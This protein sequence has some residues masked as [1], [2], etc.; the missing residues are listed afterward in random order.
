MLSS[1]KL[2]QIKTSCTFHMLLRMYTD[3]RRASGESV[4]ELRS[5]NDSSANLVSHFIQKI[6]IKTNSA[7]LGRTKD[8]SPYLLVSRTPFLFKRSLYTEN[9]S[10]FIPTAYLI[11]LTFVSPPE[12]I[13]DRIFLS[14][15]ESSDQIFP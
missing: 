13:T 2:R 14:R 7:N 4:K 9:C 10:G 3:C 11:F 8:T 5:R 6:L 15:S 1:Q 12:D